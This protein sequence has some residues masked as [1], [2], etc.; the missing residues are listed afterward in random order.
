MS[1]TYDE[2]TVLIDVSKPTLI[3]WG[4]RFEKRIKI[5]ELLLAEELGHRL[6]LK[7]KK[8]IEAIADAAIRISKEKISEP[9]VKNRIIGRMS[10]KL[11][12]IFKKKM[13]RIELT[14]NNN[15]TIRYVNIVWKQNKITDQ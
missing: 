13:D 7:N 11:Y 10:K 12:R 14:L 5:V 6:V 8:L 3:E 4:K 2:I 9:E 15:Y 1:Y